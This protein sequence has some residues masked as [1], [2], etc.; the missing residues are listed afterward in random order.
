MA[1][2]HNTIWSMLTA[3]EDPGLAGRW[4]AWHPGRLDDAVRARNEHRVE[5]PGAAA[6][7]ELRER[8]RRWGAGQDSLT[9]IDRLA[10]PA[11]RVVVTGQQPGMLA[12][13]MLTLYKTIGAIRLAR[14][15]AR[16]HPEHT[17]VPVFWVAS[18]DH[19]FDEIRAV[20]WPGT[21]GPLEEYLLPRGDWERGRMVGTLPTAPL[22]EPL[23]ER[24][25][26]S[27]NRTDFRPD[28]ETFL[29]HAY[30]D[31]ATIEDGFARCLLR[32]LAGQGL[33]IVS[34]LMDWVRR[35]AA[36]VLR[37]EFAAPGDS[38][39]RLLERTEALREAGIATALHRR[40]GAVNAF[41]IDGN[42]RRLSL[43]AEGD[44][45]QR[46]LAGEDG[47]H[48]EQPPIPLA[49]LT[50]M[51]DEDPRQFSTNAVSRPLVQDAILP[52]V[53]QVVGPGEA[54]YL[55]QV[56]VLYGDFGV[57]A[58]VRWPRPRATII[59][60]RVERQIAKYELDVEEVLAHNADELV[61]RL[62][63]RQ[64]DDDEL[65][66]VE[67]LRDRQ[68]A[69][70]RELLDQEAFSDNALQSA[71]QKLIQGM[72]KGYEKLSERILFLRER[73]QSHVTQAMST[74]S[75]SIHPTGQDQERLLN[76]IVPFAVNH[77]LDWLAGAVD[78]LTAGPDGR[79][80]VIYP[81]R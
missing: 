70:L 48:I 53:A 5:P 51:L 42:G 49:D 25:L 67:A 73:D 76:P 18:E 31:D 24:I 11:T 37:H 79:L 1:S 69:E 35:A 15:L 28:V 14:R 60:P 12:G 47:G 68:L 33:V 40:E 43:Q 4:L 45:I 34:P 46:A 54:A 32:L 21:G 71:I 77:G 72:E 8:H 57:F 62:L 10:D 44:E 17:F 26:A 65:G 19:D 13:P 78:A 41:W 80:Q 52:T 7:D 39:R 63:R 3:A 16:A 64:S 36:P 75:A 30:G 9:A 38:T 6:L 81:P 50:G 58:P 66:R 56:E 55:A 74:V 20:Y 2:P 61:E 29:R 27:T 23:L 59:E 22:L